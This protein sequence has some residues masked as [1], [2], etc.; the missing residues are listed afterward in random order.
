M[1]V[2]MAAFLSKNPS[3]ILFFEY[4]STIEKKA[5]GLLEPRDIDIPSLQY[6]K[7]RFFTQS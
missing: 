1:N 6:C 4:I 2:K 5:C 3:M 7:P